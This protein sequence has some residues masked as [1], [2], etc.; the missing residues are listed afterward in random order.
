MF[1]PLLMSK[2]V[3]ESLT[4]DQ[5]KVIDQVGL[6]METFAL[7]AAKADDDEL[8]KVYQK[9]GA[10]VREMDPAA[11]GKWRTLAEATAWKDFA[12]RSASCATLLKLAEAVA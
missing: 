4:P 2:Q 1:E 9:V 3:Y 8:A 11:L 7:Q 10:Q 5:R 6:E 12:D